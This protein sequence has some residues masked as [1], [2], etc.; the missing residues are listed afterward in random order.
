MNDKISSRHRLDRRDPKTFELGQLEIAL[1]PLQEINFRLISRLGPQRSLD[2][3]GSNSIA[4]LQSIS[5]PHHPPDNDESYLFACDP[6]GTHCN[7][8]C[9]ST[10][11]RTT[12][13]TV[14]IPGDVA[15]DIFLRSAV[16]LIAVEIDH[17]RSQKTFL[18]PG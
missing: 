15:D 13:A 9:P 2:P 6:S 8:Q 16:I 3:R 11:L 14:P 18:T 1:T 12:F 17:M 10:P 4:R 5:L 7:A